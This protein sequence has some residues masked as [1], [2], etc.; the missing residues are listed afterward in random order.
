VNH[1]V[2]DAPQ[3]GLRPCKAA[4][5]Q[6]HEIG[7]AL[8]GQAREVVPVAAEGPLHQLLGFP[9]RCLS[10]RDAISG[11]PLGLC[12]S[13]ALEWVDELLETVGLP[14]QSLPQLRNGEGRFPEVHHLRRGRR[15]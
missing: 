9:A 5:A 13:L 8:L 7:H 15:R 2:G 10:Q 14:P 4:G 1:E 11:Q 12:S 6:D 3:G